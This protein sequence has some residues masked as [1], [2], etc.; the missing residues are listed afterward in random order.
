[1]IGTGMMRTGM[2]RTGIMRTG[3]T[4][5]FP[6]AARGL[7]LL[8]LGLLGTAGARAHTLGDSYLYLQIYEDSVAGRFEIALADLN[9]GLGIA[10]TEDGITAE[11][12][13]E[14]I[15]FLQ[16]YYRSHV[17]ITGPRGPLEIDFGPHHL[18]NARGGFVQLPF[19]LPGLDGVPG[20]LTFEYSVLL[21]EEPSHRGFLLVE[22]NWATGTFAN[23]NQF[24]LVFGPS[25]RR[26]EL[27]LTSSGRLSGFLA[28][29]RLGAEHMLLGLDHI[30]FL[31]ALLLP[32]AL[33]REDGR[34]LPLDGLG[35]ALRNVVT[36]VATLV[37]AHLVALLLA[38]LGLASLPE[39]LVET[40]IAASITLAAI[41]LLVPLGKTLTRGRIL[42]IVFVLGL[43]HGLGFAGSLVQLGVLDEH[44]GLSVVAFV[45]GVEAG[46]TA[47]AIVLFPVLFLVRRLGLY[48]RIALPV[49]AVGLAV[50]SGIWVV[51]R[52]FDVD[53]PL[54]ELL[55]PAVQKVIP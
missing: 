25:S 18:L 14:R 37:A 51:E 20:T 3:M 31:V 7:L 5:L 19:E 45:L 39:A 24:S 23:E 17:T 1:M 26:Q 46:Q 10:G 32:A 15:D 54:R 34:W 16:G 35:S 53:V 29:V 41:H 49:A 36:V 6:R 38:A 13:D 11:N 40:V 9:H 4:R 42:A 33:R 27:D 22:H 44:L 55:P 43:F 47:I 28:L 30:F 48:R 52:G 8:A 2:I 50:I 21:D 12:L